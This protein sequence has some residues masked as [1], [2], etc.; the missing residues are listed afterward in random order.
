M[1]NSLQLR[2]L[3]REEVRQVDRTA[4]DEYGLPGIAL[5]ENAGRGAAQRLL[6]LGIAGNVVILAGRGNNGG[7]GFVIARH[8]ELAGIRSEIVLAGPADRLQGD[9]RTNL[10]VLCRSGFQPRAFDHT[11][12]A[13]VQSA[14]WLIDA[15]LGTGV[16]GQIR[17]PFDELIGLINASPGRTIAIDLPSGLDCDT[18]QPLGPCV[19]ASETITFVA[20]KKGFETP[21]AASFVGNVHTVSIGAPRAVLQPYVVPAIEQ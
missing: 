4:I 8:L 3:S 9:A 18:G 21:A 15:L 7:D 2:P 16:R 6:E 17:A 10:D 12:P 5:M 20:P 13:L 19:E 1:T 11:T 14:D